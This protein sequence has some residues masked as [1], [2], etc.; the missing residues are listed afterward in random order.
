MSDGNFVPSDKVLREKIFKKIKFR[1]QKK[2]LTTPISS[3]APKEFGEGSETRVYD[4]ERVMELH[5]RMAKLK[6]YLY[7]QL[8][9][10]EKFLSEQSLSLL[11]ATVDE[12]D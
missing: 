4:P 9:P 7:D 1:F 12:F 2:N 5:E 10:A 11:N 8:N 6:E 3:Q